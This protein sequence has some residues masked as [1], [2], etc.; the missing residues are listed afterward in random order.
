M[1][2]VYA[3]DCGLYNAEGKP[4][5][6]FGFSSLDKFAEDYTEF[7]RT[8]PIQPVLC[9]VVPCKSASQAE[10]I[11]RGIAYRFED[12]APY[13][14]PF[15][16]VR[17]ASKHVLTFIANEMENGEAFLGKPAHEFANPTPEPPAEEEPPPP[18]LPL[19]DEPPKKRAYVR[20]EPKPGE[21]N[22]DPKEK[23]RIYMREYRQRENAKE[24]KRKYDKKRRNDPEVRK[25]HQEYKRKSRQKMRHG[26]ANPDQLNLLEGGQDG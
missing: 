19:E 6:L 1:D 21:E 13:G 16:G 15:S 7:E 8:S 10:A 20:R 5:R 22:L 18:E 12:E 4:L 26:G 14:M 25:R 3:L 2:F 23:R 9:G 17:V 24:T 11:T